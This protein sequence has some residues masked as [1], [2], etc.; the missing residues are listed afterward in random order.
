[1]HI[2]LYGVLIY[3]AV[4][5]AAIGSADTDPLNM[6]ADAG[7]YAKPDGTASETRGYI[8]VTSTGSVDGDQ[9]NVPFGNSQGSS[10]SDLASA[11]I[12]GSLDVIV[13]LFV[14]L[15]MLIAGFILSRKHYRGRYQLEGYGSV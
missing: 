14:G 3:L 6:Q 12:E 5:V 15:S 2:V 13:I 11:L 8:R 1:M 4:F 7:V 10:I 9:Y